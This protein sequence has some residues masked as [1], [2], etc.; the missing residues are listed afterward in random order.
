MC[1]LTAELSKMVDCPYKIRDIIPLWLKMTL[2]YSLF[3]SK[4][5]YC[6]LVWGTTTTQNYNKLLLLEKK[7][8]RIFENYYGWPQYLAT[9]ELFLKHSLLK[10]NQIYYFKLLQYIMDNNLHNTSNPVT[11]TQH[12]LRRRHRPMPST[13][14]SFGRQHTDYQITSLLNKV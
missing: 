13:R 6:A 9:H 4:L 5:S 2:Y 8:L 11:A 1:K 7:L 14:T 12:I 10:A 3:F